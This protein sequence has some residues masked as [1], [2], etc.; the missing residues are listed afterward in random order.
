MDWLLGQLKSGAQTTSLGLSPSSLL[1]ALLPPQEGFLLTVEK[2]HQK[3]PPWSLQFGV[4]EKRDRL[5]PSAHMSN[6]SDGSGS[7]RE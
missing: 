6:L 7:A 1:L 4:L 2:M 5:S 3:R